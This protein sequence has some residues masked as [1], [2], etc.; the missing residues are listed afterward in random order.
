MAT[1]LQNS[2]HLK[3]K[4]LLRF[5]R[6]AAKKA[7]GENMK[8]T[9]IML[10]KTHIE[11]MSETRLSTIYMKTKHLEAPLHYMYEN[12]GSYINEDAGGKRC[13]CGVAAANSPDWG[14]LSR[15]CSECTGQIAA[16]R[17]YRSFNDARSP[18]HADREVARR[19]LPRG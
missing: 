7:R 4:R 17:E 19:L 18:L 1:I 2:M 3:L 13:S 16:A 10:L 8:V 14:P 15:S 6:V 9:S 11:T 5:L 12:K